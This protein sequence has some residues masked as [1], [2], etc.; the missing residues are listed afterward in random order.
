MKSTEPSAGANEGRPT[1][2]AVWQ[3]F[4]A[5]AVAWAERMDQW[6]KI[7]FSTP[8]GMIYVTIGRSDLYP[9]SFSEVDVCGRPVR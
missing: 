6:D 5:G 8:Y 3:A 9:D 2:K 1:D 4:V 7:K